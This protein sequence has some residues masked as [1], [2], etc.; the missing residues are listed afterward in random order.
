[1][2]SS[3][4]GYG[5]TT[6][7]TRIRTGAGST[8]RL[9]CWLRPSTTYARAPAPAAAAARA[10]CVA[11]PVST[12]GSR[13]NAVSPGPETQRTAVTGRNSPSPPSAFSTVTTAWPSSPSAI[14][15]SVRR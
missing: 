8:I 7:T 10:M 6:S 5:G 12:S 2:S 11:L 9:T 15:T 13:T 4:G 1:M 3:F 14:S